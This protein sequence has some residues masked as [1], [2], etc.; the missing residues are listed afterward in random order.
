MHSVAVNIELPKIVTPPVIINWKINIKNV[1]KE[2]SYYS[3]SPENNYSEI[4]TLWST[5]N[6]Y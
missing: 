1:I 2:W 5:F 3:N 6:L 4:L